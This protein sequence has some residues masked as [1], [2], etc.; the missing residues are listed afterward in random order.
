MSEKKDQE[1]NWKYLIA[2]SSL[3]VASIVGYYFWKKNQTTKETSEK[4]EENVKK[5]EKKLKTLE[6]TASDIKKSIDSY[7]KARKKLNSDFRIS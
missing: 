2:G 3:F 1:N 5:V 7:S 4:I 6:E